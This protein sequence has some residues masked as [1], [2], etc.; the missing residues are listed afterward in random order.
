MGCSDKQY[1]EIDAM[2]CH[3]GGEPDLDRGDGARGCLGW[4]GS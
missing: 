1:G 4:S 2:L 3:A